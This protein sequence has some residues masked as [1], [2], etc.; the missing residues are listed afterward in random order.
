MSSGRIYI[1]SRLVLP[2]LV[3]FCFLSANIRAQ[4]S[5]TEGHAL[6]FGN[7]V[8]GT[9][10]VTV[11]LTS[12][13]TG[14]VTLTAP[15]GRNIGAVLTPPAS[16]TDGAGNTI[17]YTAKAA[18]NIYAYNPGTANTMPSSGNTC[19]GVLHANDNGITAQ[20]FIW[21][22]GSINVG[23]IPAGSYSAVYNITLTV[24]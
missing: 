18:Y 5:V 6:S 10:K 9:G 12:P 1:D 21:V 20:G 3:L 19:C 23:M 7:V 11:S 14:W 16:L 4:T 8:Q 22:Y 2:L 13:N 15:S 17:P 24:Y